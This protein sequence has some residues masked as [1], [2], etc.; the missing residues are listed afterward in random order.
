MPLPKDSNLTPYSRKLRKSMT[1]QERHLWFDYLK[2]LPLT[3]HRQKVILRYIVD[4]YCD[5]AKLVIEIDGGQH[6]DDIGFA[7]DLERGSCLQN[8][9]LKLSVLRI[10]MWI[11]IFSRFVRQ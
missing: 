10:R 4:F 2:K 6:Y 7:K 3:I 5:A 8:L 1:K 11:I 9:G